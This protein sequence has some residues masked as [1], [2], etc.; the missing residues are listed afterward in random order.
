MSTP[1]HDYA[2]IAEELLKAITNDDFQLRGRPVDLL[3]DELKTHFTPAPMKPME[4][5]YCGKTVALSE[6]QSQYK[7]RIENDRRSQYGSREPTRTEIADRALAD[8]AAALAE[9]TAMHEGNAAA[10][11]NNLRIKEEIEST[12]TRLGIPRTYSEKDASSRKQI[13]PWI[14]HA[15]GYFA[16]ITRYVKTTDG[17]DN[18]AVSHKRKLALFTE[19]K[20]EAVRLDELDRTK[21]EREAAEKKAKLEKERKLMAVI[22]RHELPL[23]SDWDDV[24]EALRD[25]NPRLNL[26]VAMLQVRNDWNDGPKSVMHALYNGGDETDEA[27]NTAVGDAYDNWD[28]DGRIFRDMEWSYDAIFNT[29]EDQQLVADTMTALEEVGP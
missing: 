1:T 28:G 29:I 23:M 8:L 17:W 9:D 11:V 19:W 22:I 10:I 27:I 6:Y 25:K 16:D 3:A 12:M 20:K 24:L 14:T 21:G 13:K 26:A 7:S 15:S 2:N 5:K 4:V 18:V